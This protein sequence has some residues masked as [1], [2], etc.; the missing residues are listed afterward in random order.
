M[1]VNAQNLA[2]L[3]H[4]A[5][6]HPSRLD[7]VRKAV[8]EMLNDPFVPLSDKEGN[9][10][11]LSEKLRDIDRE[12]GEI[13]PR[14]ID[15]RRIFNDALRETFDP[16][17]RTSMHGTHTVTAGLKIQSGSS[18]TGLAGE[19]NTVQTIVEF[20]DPTN[21]EMA[22]TRIL[23]ESRQRNGQNMIYLLGRSSSEADDLATDIYRCQRIAEMHRT[24]PDQEI[25]EYCASQLDRAT[26]LS[27]QLQQK[28][29]QSLTQGSFVFR[30][31]ATA[32][33]T[34]DQ[35]MLEALKKILADVAVQVF[36]RYVEAP[37]RVETSLAEKFLRTGNPSA[38]TTALDPLGLVQ[39]SSGRPNIKTDHKAIVSI[40]DYIDRNG[41]VEGKRLLD[42]FSNDPFG[43][44]PDTV[45]YILAAMLVAGEIKLKVSGREVTAAGQQALDALKTNKSF[46]AVGI[47][48]RDER[49]S[50]ETLGRAAER[51]TNLIGD[52]IIPLE[53]EI[54]KATVKYFPGFQREYGPLS[55]KLAA[56]QLAGVE[57]V[58]TLNQEIAD[59]MF[60][61]A[62]DAPQ[63]LGGEESA[64]YDNLIWAGEVKRTL[65]NGLDGT[66]GEIQTHRREIGSLPDTGIPGE[67][68][69]EL[70]EELELL[71]QRLQKDDF[72]QHAADLNSLLTKIKA[73][74]RD[75]V[76][77]LKEQQKLRLKE[78]AEDLQ[79]L[80]D[81]E[82]LTQEEQGNVLS[83]LDGL[84]IYV[85]HDLA[86]L[87]QLLARDYDINTSLS[88]I[89]GTIQRKGQ[90]R[91]LQRLQEERDQSGEKGPAR[92]KRSIPIPASITT[93]AQLDEL[94]RQLQEI[95]AQLALYAEVEVSITV[96][97]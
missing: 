23:D 38:I 52:T 40:R 22:R 67:L 86:G 50:N 84:A 8:E 83:D 14:T 75:A 90:E 24:D 31:Q 88:A 19:Q 4:P 26:K 91:R 6:D 97:E 93:A 42:H 77:E 56:L 7:E 11:F 55:E 65:T 18:L 96:Q 10:C 39:V 3:L 73:R 20:V 36:D 47:A 78:G 35:D 72:Y 37:V 25:K 79:R 27:S 44:S 68:R 51:L 30:G 12:R 29:K 74:V 17:P 61:D 53:Q 66:L 92:L 59:I 64:L 82:E 49:P 48:L 58:R 43:W 15:V 69:R 57:R 16:L 60:T 33:T 81:W 76:G 13:P 21:Y 54:S 85:A 63:R 80:P 70:A 9:L 34:L 41:T 46:G 5:I 94:I 89:K 95:K 1:P 2:G 32:V 28:L 87:K 45:R 71:N 62:S